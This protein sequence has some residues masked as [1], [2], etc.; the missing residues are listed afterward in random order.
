MS[1]TRSASPR[2]PLIRDAAEV[3]SDNLQMLATAAVESH[4]KSDPSLQRYGARGRAR[5]IEDAEFHL[6]FLL[7]A[8]AAESI[9]QFVD[10]CGWAKILLHNGGIDVAHLADN[11]QHLSTALKRKLSKQQFS[12][13][14]EYLQAGIDA[15]PDLP[16][17]LPSQI[18]P[19]RPYSQQANAYLKALLRFDRTEASNIVLKESSKGTSVKDIYRHII[20][21][22]Q[23]EIGRLWQLGKLTV[24]HEHYC[25]AA[26]EIVMAEL[27]RHLVPQGAQRELRLLA[28]CVEGERHCIGIKMFADLMSLEGWRVEYAGQDTPT[29]SVLRFICQ[30]KPAVVAVSV[31]FAKNVRSLQTLIK[32]IRENPGCSG[33]KILIAGRA[34]SMDLCKRLGADG[35]AQCVGDGVEVAN[36]LI[37]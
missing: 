9:G 28:F 30:E 25:T 22:V 17:D 10:Y 13:V 23:Q 8:L 26:T 29:S 21:P 14:E 4:Y 24:V 34:A 11:L 20:T 7:S 12:I 5:C 2:P 1:A 18:G 35:Y 36:R 16:T 27:F 3:I 33:V 31:T 6:E 19:D 37:A 15:L 32:A